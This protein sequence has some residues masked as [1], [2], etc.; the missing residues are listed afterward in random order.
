VIGSTTVWNGELVGILAG[1]GHGDRIVIADAGL[2]VPER[3]RLVDLAVMRNLPMSTQVLAAVLADGCFEGAFLADELSSLDHN[4]EFADLL[5]GL[6][7][8]RVTHDEIKR[9][10]LDVRVIVRTGEARPY[11]NVV[12]QAGVLF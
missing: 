1:L 8:S 3:A 10:C 7:I 6:P 4:D 11:S 12:L 5:S 2:P 9:Y